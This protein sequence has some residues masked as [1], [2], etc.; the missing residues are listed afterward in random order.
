[1]FNLPPEIAAYFS[2]VWEVTLCGESNH[3]WILWSDL[4]PC[5]EF[6][7]VEMVQV[8]SSR[9]CCS[10]DLN[11]VMQDSWR[12]IQSS[13]NKSGVVCT[14]SCACC[15]CLILGNSPQSTC[16]CVYGCRFWEK[17]IHYMSSKPLVT[18]RFNYSITFADFVCRLHYPI[19]N[20]LS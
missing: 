5:I 1:M 14:R 8:V 12:W 16:S 13:L 2:S 3:S 15:W 4:K 17:S 20:F 11:K 9:L 18:S 10:K 19:W 7:Y 6:I